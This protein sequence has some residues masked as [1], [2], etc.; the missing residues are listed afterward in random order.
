M[1]DKIEFT[2]EEFAIYSF[3]LIEIARSNILAS[4]VTIFE[5][6]KELAEKM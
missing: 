1:T 5:Q 3:F 6:L 4:P 2:Y